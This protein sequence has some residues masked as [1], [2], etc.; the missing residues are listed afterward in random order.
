MIVIRRRAALAPALWILCVVSL[1]V[2]VAVRTA[3]AQPTITTPK[4]HLGHDVGE[5]YYLA[6]YA[7]MMGYW[8]VLDR[9][10]DR[11]ALVDIGTTDEGRTQTM[12][13]VTSPENHRRLEH[14]R[15][16]AKRLALAEGLTD[17]DARKLAE[18]GKAIVWIDG[19]LHASEVVGAQQLIE[20]VYRLVSGTDAETRRFL[21]DVI[22]LCVPANPDGMDLVSGWYMRN[23]DPK[24]RSMAGL[25]RLYQKYAGHDNNRDSYMVNLRETENMHR[26]LYREWFPQILYN[27]HQTGPVGTVVFMP[28][29]RDPF[30]YNYDPLIPLGVEAVGTA[31][32]SRFVAEGKPGS[33][34]RSAA[35][36]ST[37]WN[38]GLRTTAYFHN[39]IGLLT[40]IIGS[41]TPTEIPLVP[42]KL[43]PSG[44]Y[45]FPILPQVWH[46]RQS[47]E[48]EVS[49]NFAVIDLA[50]R[51]RDTL[52]FNIYQMGRNAIAKGSRDTWTFT[53]R[54]VDA[55]V[56][57]AA[58][59]QRPGADAGPRGG[60]NTG[61]VAT[62]YL[63]S[64][65]TPADRDPRGYVIPS[66]QADFP[67]A[68]KF[69]NTL[70]K[71]GI[72]VHR[73]TAAFQVGTRTYPAGSFVVKAAQAFRPYVM[74]TFEPQDHPDD[75]AYP[76]GPPRPPYDTAG[77]TLAYTM[78]V[79]FDRILE[80]FNGPFEVVP[81]VLAMPAA[82][83]VGVAKGKAAGF[84]IDPRLNDAFRTVNRLL[85]SGERVVRLTAPW[86]EGTRTWPAGSFYVTAG[87]KTLAALNVLV[88]QTG[89][90]AYG[91]TAKAP[92]SA[93]VLRPVRIGLWDRYGGSMP[94]GWTRFLLEQFE[95]PFEVVYAPTLDAGRLAERFDVLIFPDDAIPAR[96]GNTGGYGGAMPPADEIPQEYR[97]RLGSVSVAKTVPALR[98]FVEDGGVLLAIGS[99][100]SVAEH[101]RLPLSNALVERTP[102]GEVRPL[103][104]E[105]FFVPGSVLQAALDV[106]QPV[107]WGMAERADVMFETSPAFRLTPGATSAGVWPVA[108][109]DS[110]KPL[111]SGWAWG[112]GYLKDATAIVD[113]AVGNGRVVLYGPEITFRA[114]PHG[115]YK[116]LFNGIY[117]LG[118]GRIAR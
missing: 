18:E 48:Y 92:A 51:Q 77:W 97:G 106:R 15:G 107:A 112:Q 101:F 109:F 87:S 67:T 88:S 117:R 72:A 94:S 45:P 104:S 42:P 12:A 29:F 74:D 30:N 9:E 93:M 53:P 95:F 28:P 56:K 114:Q 86:Q 57:Q 19:G 73:A 59:D 35:P 47:I 49:A 43:L 38:G 5:D 83:V 40:E 23:A 69:V 75:F 70:L 91:V 118:G 82:R 66:D 105:K 58:K 78:G 25:P 71:N 98:Q 54:R 85:A 116:L 64:M 32:H 39:I 80:A 99:S 3:V 21:N 102:Q 33:T 7:D 111:R 84:V 17:A 55:I 76:G 115:T 22:V 36:Y 63:A 13:I 1:A 113:A 50:S 41:P 26:V 37:W 89:T 24:K 46:M 110:D 44:D 4:A 11:L 52:L 62:S 10:S 90:P 81:D 60:R 108:W 79:S 2:T 31:M 20:T 34:M 103:P 68:V 16:I 61:V 6:T 100:T 14:Y 8:R 96:D 27:H 65:Q